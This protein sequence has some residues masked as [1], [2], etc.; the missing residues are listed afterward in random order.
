M[1][2]KVTV[3]MSVYNSERYLR[4]AIE[5]ILNQTF[6]DFDFLIIND[7][8]TD[9]SRKIIRLYD[10][11]R[12]R[13]IDN[14]GNIGLT[15]S[16]NKGIALAQGE[17]LARM[18]AD[19][20]SLP[21]RLETQVKFLNSHPDTAL[22]GSAALIIDSASHLLETA[23]R[24]ISDRLLPTQLFWENCLVHS[25][26]MGRTSVFQEFQYPEQYAVAQDY[27]LWTQIAQ[28]YPIAN[29]AEPLL[30]SRRHSD[31]V[32]LMHSSRQEAVVKR[33][34]RRQLEHL[35]L[36]PLSDTDVE[37]HY[38]LLRQ[39]FH[40][41]QIAMSQRYAVLAWILRIVEQ[42]RRNPVYDH[43]YFSHQLQQN[44]RRFFD[45]RAGYQSG[46][47]GMVLLYK[48]LALFPTLEEQCR[49][50]LTCLKPV[51]LFRR[52]IPPLTKLL[53]LFMRSDKA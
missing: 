35:G 3:L 45:A 51:P 32:T 39:Q 12:V 1:K 41:K 20:V 4:E 36:T 48:G 24:D 13:L 47:K 50:L 33:I 14:E 21:E 11:A 29:L 28:K 9:E 30:C 46:V 19:D 18:D 34:F 17:Y 42:H 40:P 26:V 38:Q 6:E 16:L 10:D 25:S 2:P 15:L 31:S 43:A 7:G 5:S 44:W 27:W 52:V 37:L 23:Y 8:S 53:N 22:V 49:Y